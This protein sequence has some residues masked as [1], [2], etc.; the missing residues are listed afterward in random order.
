MQNT[1]NIGE[2]EFRTFIAGI[3]YQANPHLTEPGRWAVWAEAGP[4]NTNWQVFVIQ[5]INAGHET[6]FVGNNL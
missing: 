3:Q 4:G 1:R 5:K 2:N 6:L